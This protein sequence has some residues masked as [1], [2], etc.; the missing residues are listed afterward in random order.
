ME[1]ERIAVE[2]HHVAERTDVGAPRPQP[3]RGEEREHDA[4]QRHTAQV[5]LRARRQQ[6]EQQHERAGAEDDQRGQ[7]RA[8]GDRR[9]RDHRSESRETG[10]VV[11]RATLALLSTWA[12]SA[13]TEASVLDVNALG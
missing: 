4:G 2:Q 8:E 1:E 11:L 7:E 13:C 9:R 3:H 12:M 6:V 10:A 5:I